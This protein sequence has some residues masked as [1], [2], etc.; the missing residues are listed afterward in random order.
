MYE[1][2][3]GTSTPHGAWWCQ[4]RTA[5]PKIAL[6]QLPKRHPE[7]RHGSSAW[8]P[9]STSRRAAMM[10][11]RGYF[12]WRDYTSPTT[13]SSKALISGLGRILATTL[14]GTLP[15]EVAKNSHDIER[16]ISS[17]LRDQPQR[18]RQ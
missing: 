18:R 13:G 3:Q 14:A 2:H 7:Q 12:A 16:L 8:K 10:G 1:N 11:G 4:N 9:A 5:L 17:E 15:H 6:T